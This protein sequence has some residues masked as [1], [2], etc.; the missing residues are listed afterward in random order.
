MESRSVTTGKITL[1]L[2]AVDPLS[3]S[4]GKYGEL[5]FLDVIIRRPIF[6]FLSNWT[7]PE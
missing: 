1:V 6:A 4:A 3:E 5:A 7:V 2:S